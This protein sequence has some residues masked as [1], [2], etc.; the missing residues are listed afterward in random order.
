MRTLKASAT[1][2]ALL[3]LAAVGAPAHAALIDC[4]DM[5][6]DRVTN[7]SGTSAVSACQYLTP[8]NPGNV[9]SLENINA[10]RFFGFDDWMGGDKTDL[11]ESDLSGSWSIVDADFAARD[12]II[13]FKS[14]AGTNLTAFLLNELFSSGTWTTPFTDPPF[15]LGPPGNGNNKGKQGKARDVS[16]YTIAYRNTG[17]TVVPVPEP[18]VLP[19]LG[20]GLLGIGLGRRF[21]R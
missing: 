15:D 14:G 21:R 20:L 1:S 7:G 9:A 16:H 18:G 5:L 2:A 3:I 13:V 6:L 12:Y 4:S 17:T 19:L 8:A 11:G 10:A